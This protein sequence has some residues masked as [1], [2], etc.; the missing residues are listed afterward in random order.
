MAIILDFLN[1]KFWFAVPARYVLFSKSSWN[2][3]F[4]CSYD[5]TGE[6]IVISDW[7]FDVANFVLQFFLEEWPVRQPKI[8]SWFLYGW[9][10]CGVTQFSFLSLEN[11]Y[12]FGATHRVTFNLNDVIFASFVIGLWTIFILNVQAEKH[13]WA[14]EEDV[15]KWN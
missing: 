14:Y 1:S 2:R 11:L 7:W 15:A 6:S 13:L 9:I 5:S 10:K 8:P 12:I 4:S 3:L